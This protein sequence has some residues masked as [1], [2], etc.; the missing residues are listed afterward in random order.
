M[1]KSA[2]RGV[3]SPTYV[4][5]YIGLMIIIYYTRKDSKK[6]DD[7][8]AIVPFFAINYYCEAFFI[9]NYFVNYEHYSTTRKERERERERD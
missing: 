2:Y 3:H 4:Y 8:H 7:Q 5:I 9:F 1:Q 6:Q